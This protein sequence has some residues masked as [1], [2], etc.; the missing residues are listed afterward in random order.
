MRFYNFG[1][2]AYEYVCSKQAISPV[3]SETTDS[4]L[5]QMKHTFPVLSQVSLIE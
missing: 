3:T 1:D 4:F 2:I 5:Q